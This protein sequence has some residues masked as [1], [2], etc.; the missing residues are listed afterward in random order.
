VEVKRQS[1]PLWLL[2]SRSNLQ[3]RNEIEKRV[4]SIKDGREEAVN[5]IVAT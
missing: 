2:D 4:W 5:P 1:I 3:I